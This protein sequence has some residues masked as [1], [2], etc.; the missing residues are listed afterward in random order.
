MIVGC[1]GAKVGGCFWLRMC[2]GHCYYR[3]GLCIGREQ[4]TAANYR[5]AV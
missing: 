2:I 5:F 3:L 1:E 4:M